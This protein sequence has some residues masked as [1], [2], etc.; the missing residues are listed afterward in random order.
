[1]HNLWGWLWGQYADGYGKYR[2][3]MGRDVLER[4]EGVQKWRGGG[5]GG[6]GPPSSYDPSM[7]PAEGGPKIFQL[8]LG[9]EAKFWLSASN[10]GRGGGGGSRG[11]GDG[12]SNTSLAM[13]G[14]GGTMLAA[15]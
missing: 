5:G 7:V 8:P 14:G 11:G 2:R 9:T 1:M 13:G 10:I 3:A 4:G 12:R 6:L 15:K